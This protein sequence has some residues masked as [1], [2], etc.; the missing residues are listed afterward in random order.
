MLVIGGGAGFGAGGPFP[1]MFEAFKWYA[2]DVVTAFLET[3]V[4][5]LRGLF[6]QVEQVA[7]VSSGKPNMT[8]RQRLCH[9][10]VVS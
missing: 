9:V 4:R 10:A 6:Q 7:N 2:V 3:N 8:Q 1:I 5:D